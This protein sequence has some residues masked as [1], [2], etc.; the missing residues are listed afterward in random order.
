MEGNGQVMLR[1]C[2]L[3]EK[4]PPLTPADVLAAVAAVVHAAA[5]S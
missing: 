4:N 5:F 3:N 2:C 1:F